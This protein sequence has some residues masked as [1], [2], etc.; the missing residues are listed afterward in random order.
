MQQQMV[1][2]VEWLYKASKNKEVVNM[3]YIYAA[4]ALDIMNEYCFARELVEV[5]KPDFGKKGFDDLD[6][7][8]ADTVNK[9][10]APAM[11]EILDFRRSLVHQV[12]AIRSGDDHAHE[13]QSPNH[14]PRTP[15]QHTPTKRAQA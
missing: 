2:L 6:R 8:L 12:Q 7:F 13:G 5:L 3:K 4:V 10:L 9:L 14:F 11:P 15:V 1:I